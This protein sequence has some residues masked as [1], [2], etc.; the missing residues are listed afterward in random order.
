MILPLVSELYTSFQFWK[1]RVFFIIF[2]RNCRSS[3]F[4]RWTFLS[5]PLTPT[6]LKILLSM[7]VGLEPEILMPQLL[8]AGVPAGHHCAWPRMIS[9]SRLVSILISLK[10]KIR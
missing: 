10:K 8:Q 9:F 7:Q 5:L 4:K 1:A 3:F 2:Y 6:H